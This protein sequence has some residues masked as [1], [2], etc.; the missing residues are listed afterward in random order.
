M[1]RATTDSFVT[2]IELLPTGKQAK[3]L[4]S[5]FEAA[6]QVFNACLGESLKRLKLMRESRAYRTARKLK[7]EERRAAF[8]E[9]QTKHGF[10]EY[11]LHSWCKQFTKSWINEH[12]GA[13]TTEKVA[14]E[15]FQ[16]VRE[17]SFGKRGRPR[18]C[19]K[20][21]LRAVDGKTQSCCRWKGDRIEWKGLTVRA[22]VQV[23][24][25]VVKHGLA[26]PVKYVRI[27]RRVIRGKERF[28]AQLVCKGQPFRKPSHHPGVGIVGVD[29]GPQTIAYVGPQ[30]ARLEVFCHEL[31]RDEQQLRRLL[32]SL[33][34]SRR[35]NN[36]GNF[37][38]DGT[39]KII[40][41]KRLQWND[42]SR[43]LA[44]RNRVRELRRKEAAFR[45]NL[46][47]QLVA[48]VLTMG[49]DVRL[50]SLDYSAWQRRRKTKK[51]RKKAF[52]R[53][54]GKRAPGGFVARLRSEANKWNVSVTEFDPRAVKLSQ[55]CHC[56]SITKKSLSER[57]HLCSQCGASAQR[58]LFSAFLAR[59]V[60]DG[61]LKADEAHKAWPSSCAALEAALSPFKDAMEGLPSSLGLRSRGRAPCLQNDEQKLGE[62]TDVVAV[63]KTT[64]ESRGE[65][66]EIH[67]T[68]VFSQRR[69]HR[70]LDRQRPYD[71]TGA[72]TG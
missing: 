46:H 10:R 43:Y 21:Q 38:S 55:S 33:D 36:P 69:L 20:G 3:R 44:V 68:P 63:A 12:I 64:G 54:L 60:E 14:T 18:F 41:G 65:P 62:T 49:D 42:S 9:V 34:R 37:K 47:G 59:F 58:D 7:G 70:I 28:F 53:S 22:Q 24:D 67:Q 32:R 8:R 40:P 71:P 13:R 57:W 72:D 19:R 61:V 66:S 50:E 52:G 1:A 2:E 29:L 17:F 5:K 48:R 39:I 51:G 35:A 56:G 16:I 30:A 25:A 27:T 45:R 31:K 15:A 23:S 26:A 4:R 6:R 11:D